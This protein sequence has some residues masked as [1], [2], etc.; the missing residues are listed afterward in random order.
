[1]SEEEKAKVRAFR[2]MAE[3]SDDFKTAVSETNVFFAL[4]KDTGCLYV[5]WDDEDME[6]LGKNAVEALREVLK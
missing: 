1:M 5:V 3:G 4:E 6:I 2:N